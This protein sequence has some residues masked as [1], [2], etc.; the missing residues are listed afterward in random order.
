MLDQETKDKL[1]MISKMDDMITLAVTYNTASFNLPE[2]FDPEKMNDPDYSPRRLLEIYSSCVYNNVTCQ[3]E[4]KNQLKANYGI[5]SGL[6]V[7]TPSN[8]LGDAVGL[9]FIKLTRGSLDKPARYMITLDHKQVVGERKRRQLDLIEQALDVKVTD[10]L[11]GFTD[12]VEDW[13]G[14]NLDEQIKH[15]AKL[16]PTSTTLN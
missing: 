8:S 2:T 12:E 9:V 10:V 5:E 16:A 4:G 11:G 13:I 14:V 3:K 7:C 6:I 15:L 1:I